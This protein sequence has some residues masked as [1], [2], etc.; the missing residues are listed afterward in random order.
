[1][2]VVVRT[3]LLLRY[4][5]PY[6]SKSAPNSGFEVTDTTTPQKNP[7]PESSRRRYPDPP[8]W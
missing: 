1:M 7:P 4:V 2:V 8:M 5:C 6:R 3:M